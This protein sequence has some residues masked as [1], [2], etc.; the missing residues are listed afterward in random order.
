[1]RYRKASNQGE[2]QNAITEN[3]NSQNSYQG[4]TMQ[5]ILAQNDV[6]DAFTFGQSRITNEYILVRELAHRLNNEY[7]SLIGFTS[8][9]AARSSVGEVRAALSE[10]TD[11]LHKYAGVHRAL[12]MPTYSTTIDAS[13]YIRTLCQSI[14]RARLDRRGIELVLAESPL[15]LYSEQCWKLGMIV[16]ELITNSARHAFADRGGTIRIELANFGPLAQCSFMD[17][18]SSK[19]SSTP[20]QGLKIIDALAREL[21]GEIV[22]RFGSDGATSILIFPISGE[23]RQAKEHRRMHESAS[24]PLNTDPAP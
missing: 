21:N 24:I 13:S 9:I 22:H 11:L 1:M 18:G 12:Q 5:E 4:D 15:Q 2:D 8:V 3:P 7:A 10:V 23:N 14:K 16:S 20:G 17:N 6:A 19:Q